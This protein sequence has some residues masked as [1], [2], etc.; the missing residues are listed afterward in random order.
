MA[1]FT[2]HREKQTEGP[3]SVSKWIMA[4]FLSAV[5]CCWH[6][7][8][9]LAGGA[10]AL[11]P[12]F[13]D[14]SYLT[15]AAVRLHQLQL[16]GFSAFFSHY[17]VAPAHS[18]LSTLIAMLG[19]SFFGVVPWAAAAANGVALLLVLRA[20]FGLA[21]RL[22]LPVA[23]ALAVGFLFHPL[24][25]ILIIEFRPDTLVAILTA[26]GTAWLIIKPNSRRSIAASAAVC[27]IALLGKP[28]IFYFTLLMFG[29]AFLISS[30]DLLDRRE[31][32]EFWIRAG[33]M[34][35]VALVI[36]LPHYLIAAGS[37]WGYINTALFGAHAMVW[38]TPMPIGEQMAYYLTGSGGHF[39]QG[40]W[41]FLSAAIA[42]LTVILNK[43]RYRDTERATII[44]HIALLLLISWAFVSFAT[45]KTPFLGLSVAAYLLT[46]CAVGAV[47]IAERLSMPAQ[48][49][50]AVILVSFGAVA[51]VSPWT[52]RYGAPLD[53][54]YARSRSLLL[55]RV[56]D[57]LASQ[58]NIDQATIVQPV[59]AQY[60]SS[61]N[62]AYSLHK[63]GVFGFDSR[64]EVFATVPEAYRKVPARFVVEIS[65]S[66]TDYIRYLPSGPLIDEI[67][68]AIRHD[69]ALVLIG[70]VKDDLR[71]GGVRLYERRE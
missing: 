6:I 66:S 2:H 60:L 26:I 50:L 65:P 7:R 14:V 47:F 17:F 61:Y 68:N 13:D 44:V 20:F 69:S 36:A 35:A 45:I 71:G 67:S 56:V 23:T 24:A 59:I 58:D 32:R 34:T 31:W 4:A 54:D 25:G 38:A 8:A 46:I 42:L 12:T 70:E 48:W 30:R 21:S 16:G 19:Y 41:V 51:F 53:L 64:S 49:F 33:I 37:I 1:V 39:A 15:D 18:P 11:P 43:Y 55:D 40:P 62:L 10:F 57:L 28:S 29:V 63:R 5:V 9:S 3:K 22:S 52:G 27:G